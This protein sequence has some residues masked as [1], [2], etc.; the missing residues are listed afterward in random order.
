MRRTELS[1]AERLTVRLLS[2]CSIVAAAVLLAVTTA[3]I[4]QVLAAASVTLEYQAR[5]GAPSLERIDGIA[6]A[7][8]T[9]AEVT[10]GA[11]SGERILLASGVLVGGLT[12]VA[13]ALAVA[14]LARR[15]RSGQPFVPSLTRVA[16]IAAFVLLVGPTVGGFLGDL[17]RDVI[18]VRLGA[19]ALPS[20]FTL[21]LSPWGAAIALALFALVLQ[22][23][24][25]LQRDSDGLV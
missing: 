16:W 10:T 24:E 11:T 14:Y 22:L 25:R 2:V 12:W 9:S 21:D 1:R 3:Q 13:T 18:L 8:G 20:A 17:G 6:S 19:G 4:A 23:G 5:A 7:V 15:V